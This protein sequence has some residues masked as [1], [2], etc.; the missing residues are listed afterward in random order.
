MVSMTGIRKA[1]IGVVV[2]VA[3]L[4]GCNGP[5]YR[6]NVPPTPTW[7]EDIPVYTWQYGYWGPGIT[8]YDVL[9][10]STYISDYYADP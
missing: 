7:A 5:E 6:P 2:A 8:R 1:L 10:M 3:M 9:P 4:A